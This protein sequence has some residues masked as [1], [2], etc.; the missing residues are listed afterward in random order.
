[1]TAPDPPPGHTAPQ[2]SIVERLGPFWGAQRVANLLRLDEEG[3]SHQRTTRQVLALPTS[4]HAFLYPVWQFARTPAGAVIVKPLIHTALHL[5]RRDD[6]T[7]ALTLQLPAPELDGLS[8][9]EW[10]R[11]KQAPEILTRY[12]RIR[13]R[14]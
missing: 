6:W 7:L 2:H 10:D 4:D 5:W 11:L 1:M 9:I 12:V 3:L 13:A 8:P 14:L